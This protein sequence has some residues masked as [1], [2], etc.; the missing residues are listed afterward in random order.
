VVTPELLA[1]L[2]QVESAGNPVAQPHWR[3]RLSWNPLAL[4]QPAS[5]GVGMLGVV[6]KN[7]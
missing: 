4:Y 2:A 6:F 3:L 1:A 5:S 7:R